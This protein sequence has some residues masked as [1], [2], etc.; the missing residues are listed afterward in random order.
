MSLR[1]IT[2]CAV[3]ALLLASVAL[4]A[5]CGACMDLAAKPACGEKHD[6]GASGHEHDST[7]MGGHCADC[8]DHPGITGRE[9]ARHAPVS[10]FMFL[11]C[12]R[13]IC[14]QAAGEQNATIYR[15]RVDAHRL[16][17]DRTTFGVPAE[18][19]GLALR[20]VH[21]NVFGSGKIAS[22]NSAYHPL[23]VSLKI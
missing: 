18:N 12:A 9:L 10:E 13:R 15:N 14:V 19:A 17:G 2:G 22:G 7:V 3:M 23:V 1:R 11:D 4:P 20:K 21:R 6:A 8:G 16:V 5:M